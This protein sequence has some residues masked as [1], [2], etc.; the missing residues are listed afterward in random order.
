[1]QPLEVLGWVRGE[2]VRVP[3]QVHDAAPACRVTQCLDDP[4]VLEWQ[5]H[6]G[7]GNPRAQERAGRHVAQARGLQQLI[8]GEGG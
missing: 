3:P 1:M 4:A 7:G 6:L 5:Q 2:V 8:P